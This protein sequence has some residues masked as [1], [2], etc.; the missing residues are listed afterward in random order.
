VDDVETVP[1][2]TP[3]G[4]LREDYSLSGLSVCPAVGRIVPLAMFP[5]SANL[6]VLIVLTRSQEPRPFR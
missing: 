5:G 4:T 2:R 1:E 6:E 3:M